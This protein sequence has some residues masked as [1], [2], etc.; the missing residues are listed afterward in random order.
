MALLTESL[1]TAESYAIELSRDP[2]VLAGCVSRFVVDQ[3]GP[4][5]AV[6]MFVTG[7]RQRL[8]HVGR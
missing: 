2:G 3:L 1:D 4:G 5:S 8:P 7:A 6:S